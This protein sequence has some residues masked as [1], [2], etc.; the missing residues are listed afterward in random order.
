M[1][2]A[3]AV[4]AVTASLGAPI[5]AGAFPTP[6]A[7]DTHGLAEADTGLAAGFPAS[8]LD[9]ALALHCQEG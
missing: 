4:C 6:V 7:L 1:V 5:D 9:A 8:E 3:D 2:T